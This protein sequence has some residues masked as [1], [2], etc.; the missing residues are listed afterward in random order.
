M[1]KFYLISAA[2]ITIGII[3]LGIGET[4]GGREDINNIHSGITTNIENFFNRNQ[5]LST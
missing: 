4:N 1:K 2:I 5:T 3:L